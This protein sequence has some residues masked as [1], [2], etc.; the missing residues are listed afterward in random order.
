VRP[1]LSSNPPIRPPSS[2]RFFSFS[3]R[4]LPPNHLSPPITRRRA[5]EPFLFHALDHPRRSRV[6]DPQPPLNQ[7]RRGLSAGQH[8]ILRLL[9]DFI[10]RLLVRRLVLRQRVQFFA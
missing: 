8:E 4:P 6:S 3:H 9:V 2:S 1:S 7:G 5:D 10:L